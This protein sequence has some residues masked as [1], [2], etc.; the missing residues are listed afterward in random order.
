MVVPCALPV[1]ALRLIVRNKPTNLGPSIR[2]PGWAEGKQKEETDGDVFLGVALR[3]ACTLSVKKKE[4]VDQNSSI[5]G[6]EQ[7]KDRHR[8]HAVT[9][10]NRARR[11]KQ[12]EAIPLSPCLLGFGTRL[13]LKTSLSLSICLCLSI[14]LLKPSQGPALPQPLPSSFAHEIRSSPLSPKE[15]L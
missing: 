9:I 3:N 5:S 1:G 6:Y 14:C 8:I 7:S 10:E 15:M 4:K 11:D 12:K 13:A 2:G